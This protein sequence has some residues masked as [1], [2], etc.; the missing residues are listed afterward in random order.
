MAA[1]KPVGTER[2][3]PNGY[4][5]IKVANPD[6][7]TQWRLKHHLVAEETLGRPLREDERV[8]FGPKG[9][10]CFDPNNII[11]Q[12]QGRTSQRR[13]LAQIEARIAEL[14]AEKSQIEK[15]LRIT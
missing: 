8:T 5:Y 11:V 7:T 14:Q 6:K 15:E 9:K 12:R 2:V 10:S 3:A 13:R 1:E 4:H